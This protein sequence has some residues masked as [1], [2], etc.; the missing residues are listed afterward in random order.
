MLYVADFTL[1][2]VWRK[3]L[4]ND[5]WINET[6]GFG[7]PVWINPYGIAIDEE[8]NKLY[9]S[10]L[11]LD[12]IY[13]K[14]IEAK[15]WVGI[16]GQLN[17]VPDDLIAWTE[18][19]M[20]LNY[21]DLRGP[22]GEQGPIG[23]QGPAGPTGPQGEPG[24]E[25]PQGPQGIPGITGP[26]GPQGEKGVTGDQG[27]I[28]PAGP[29]GP[30]GPK[31]E[32][33]DTGPTGPIGPQGP[34]GNPGADGADGKSARGFFTPLKEFND[35]LPADLVSDGV[36]VVL[37]QPSVVQFVVPVELVF[38]PFE[39]PNFGAIITVEGTLSNGTTTYTTEPNY[40]SVLKISSSGSSYTW[41][42]SFALVVTTTIPAGTYTAS[43]SVGMGNG[44][45]RFTIG[46]LRS[47][48]IIVAPV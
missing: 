40:A 2:E 24:P 27:P 28:G 20:F 17:V 34:D 47:G 7:V 32:V 11:G 33:G 37:A 15:S 21:G 43:W 30:Q 3:D 14:R 42:S 46:R 23:P 12:D 22:Q 4:L 1:N 39:E 41:N 31:G 13:V 35:P 44:Q 29:Q 10:D 19:D 18:N 5:T 8:N 36:S 45:G 48:S 38:D 25:G 26:Q 6:D 16:D 9:V